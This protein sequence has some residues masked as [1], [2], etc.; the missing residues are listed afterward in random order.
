MI[1]LLRRTFKELSKMLWLPTLVYLLTNVI[2]LLLGVSMWNQLLE[3]S[4]NSLLLNKL[5]A[6]FD[7]GIF[8]D[9]WRINYP[10]LKPL[11]TKSLYVIPLM[12]LFQTYLAGGNIDSLNERYYNLKRYFVQ[13]NKYF[14]RS[15]RLNVLVFFILLLIAFFLI[16]LLV[17]IS[18]YLKDINEIQ[19]FLRLGPISLVFVFLLILVF[20]A[21][22]YCFQRIFYSESQEVR[23]TFGSSVSYILNNKITFA[24]RFVF[25]V[26]AFT[27]LLFY[28]NAEKLIF[29]EGMTTVIF[30]IALQQ[31]Y[32]L[33]KHFLRFWDL[34]LVQK[35]QDKRPI[36][37]L[38]NGPFQQ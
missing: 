15:F 23:K 12:F 38:N 2:P 11:L 17:V 20:L 28:L 5:V 27:G 1:E 25:Y 30:T 32:I 8:M 21:K 7:Y 31:L 3:L 18:K 9:F 4:N 24:F 26:L 34:L 22:D 37:S 29:G 6:S 35:I 14:W 13:C 36:S 10:A 16:C 19:L 33:G